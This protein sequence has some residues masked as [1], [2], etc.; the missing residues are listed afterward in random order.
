VGGAEALGSD[1]VDVVVVVGVAVV[2]VVGGAAAPGFFCPGKLSSGGGA[3]PK[4]WVATQHLS[5]VLQRVSTL[6]MASQY[7][8]SLF[9]THTPGHDSERTRSSNYNSSN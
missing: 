8:D 6:R 7:P 1:V 5:P 9:A 2:V 4:A 3:S